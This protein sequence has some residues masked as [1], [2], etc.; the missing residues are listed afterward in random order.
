M[1]QR[2]GIPALLH[3]NV[4]RAGQRLALPVHRVRERRRR[5][6]HTLHH[7]PDRCRQA[8]LPPRD[9]TRTVLQQVDNQDLGYGA[10]VQR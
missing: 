4:H 9:D 7:H 2:P 10:G 5:L 3:R 8:V 1:G 6:P